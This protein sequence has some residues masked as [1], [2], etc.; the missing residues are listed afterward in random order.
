LEHFRRFYTLG[1]GSSIGK[2]E[3]LFSKLDDITIAHQ[4][5]KL[6]PA[7]P[8]NTTQLAPLNATCT[9]EDFQKADI[10]IA[11]ILHAER[12]PKTEKLLKLILDTGID[13]RTV[14]SGIAADYK[15]EQI[16]GTQVCI[17]AN[18]APR[19][20]KGIES[21]GM[22]LMAEQPDGKLLF[23]RPDAIHS[24]NGAKVK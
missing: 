9:F 21:K 24:V 20:I 18:L 7:E 1:A 4:I 8:V 11:T 14:V 10:R 12:V 13:E 23:V 22:I 16:I 2:S 5:S 6:K 15:P 19:K 17:V 3:L